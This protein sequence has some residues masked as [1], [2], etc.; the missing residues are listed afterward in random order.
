M[1]GGKKTAIFT[2]FMSMLTVFGSY[3]VTDY[4]IRQHEEKMGC[5]GRGQFPVHA[6]GSGFDAQGRAI[7]SAPPL[8]IADFYVEHVN[9]MQYT[10][11]ML[12]TLNSDMAMQKQKHI[13]LAT[14]VTAVDD[15]LQE[16]H[17]IIVDAETE[18]K[19]LKKRSRRARGTA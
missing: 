9:F 7:P 13:D 1:K 6:V 17:E 15:V 11:D 14:K 19:P 3:V 5:V 8:D 12:A 4:R 2:V 18:E 10:A 16:I